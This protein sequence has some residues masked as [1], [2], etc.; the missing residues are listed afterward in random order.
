M[1][2]KG[3]IIKSFITGCLLSFLCC[4][5][6]AQTYQAGTFKVQSLSGNNGTTYVRFSPALNACEGGNHLTIL[7]FSFFVVNNAANKINGEFSL[8]NTCKQSFAR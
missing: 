7:F 2:L 5:S 8:T 4:S 1:Q 6:N 3:F